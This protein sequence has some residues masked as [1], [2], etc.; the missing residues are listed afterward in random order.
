MFRGMCEHQEKFETAHKLE[1]FIIRIV[2]VPIFT[3]AMCCPAIIYTSTI[4]SV[5]IV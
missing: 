2:T 3:N 1:L 5:S 4:L